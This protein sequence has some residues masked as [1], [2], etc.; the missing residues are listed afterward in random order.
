MPQLFANNA[1]GRL[2]SAITNAQTTITLQ[3]GQGALFPSPTGGDFFHATLFQ[4]GTDGETNHEIVRCTARSG[5]VLTVTR[6]QEGT[7]G[8]AFD[9]TNPIE[10]RVTRDT[11]NTLNNAS[12]T[13][14][15]L[16]ASSATVGGV[17]VT[18]TSH[19]LSA[20]A[21]TTSAELAGVISDETGTG[22][23]VFANSPTLTGTPAAP[24]AAAGTNTTQLATTAHVFAERANTATL[25]NK[26]LTSP[27]ITAA[28]VSDTTIESADLETFIRWNASTDGYTTYASGATD[29]HRAMRRCL[30]LDNGTVNYYLDPVDSTRKA[31]GSVAVLDGTDGQVMVEI[32]KFY[33]KKTLVGSEHTWSL[34]LTPRTGY[35]VYP[36]FV[37]D[38]VEVNHRYLGAYDACL[39]D[40][41]A[42]SYVG[43]TNLDDMTANLDLVADKLA[44]VSGVYP[45]VG[46]T[47]AECR[48]LSANRGLGWRQVDYYLWSAVL[49]LY[50]TEYG[51]FNS[52]L[53][54]G[55]G[56]TNGSYLASSAVQTDSPHT[57]AGASNWL[58]NGSTNALSGAGVSAKPGTSFMSYRGLENLYGNCWTWVDG[59]NVINYQAWLSNTRAHFAD[60]TT[61]NYT[62]T[63]STLPAAVSAAYINNV[64]DQT[65][66][67][68]ATASG[69]SSTTFVTDALWT[70]TGNRV[71]RVGG[72][73]SNAA[74]AGAFALYS[75]YAS[76]SSYRDIGARLAF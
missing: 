63:G 73:A 70:A 37:K 62:S 13:T 6:A 42:S 75:D 74:S 23:L 14:S 10:L 26:T 17:A 29:I 48:T 51:H 16:A 34:S 58:G 71:V 33:A 19:K 21:A 1:K 57:V 54:L 35:T 32:P 39:W 66:F 68:P 64:Q 20:F 46:V 72:S 3:T 18:T 30:L 55:A 31:D 41:S 4:Y 43:G 36:A 44:S 47:R 56:N 40:A 25:T 22:A 45:L 49:L 65:V 11:I 24:T 61:T 69:G 15:S 8:R 59:I 50:L 76:S 28:S 52:Q 7:S 9:A 2:Q 12:V 67:L 27:A 60:D 53:K 5:D 38:G